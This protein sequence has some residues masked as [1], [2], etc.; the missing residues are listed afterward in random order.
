MNRE[1]NQ[2]MDFI[3]WRTS[4]S[5]DAFTKRFSPPNLN[6]FYEFLEQQQENAGFAAAEL[7]VLFT[8]VLM[9][10]LVSNV[11]SF[12]TIDEWFTALGE[13]WAAETT[14][15]QRAMLD[16]LMASRPTYNVSIMV[17]TGGEPRKVIPR[18]AG[19][20]KTMV[21]NDRVEIFRNTT[22][23]AANRL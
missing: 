17:Y 20:F 7:L 11:E 18:T 23:Q 2:V 4:T 19:D 6:S 9:D 16:R 22:I 13:Y 3:L 5:G 15:W 8:E 10:E 21:D 14:R 12:D 1:V